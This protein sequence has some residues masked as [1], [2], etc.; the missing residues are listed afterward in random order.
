MLTNFLF[1]ITVSIFVYDV[2]L[3]CELI[4]YGNYDMW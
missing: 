3:I 1:W 2:Y 4:R